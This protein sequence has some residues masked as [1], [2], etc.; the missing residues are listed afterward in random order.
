MKKLILAIVIIFATIGAKAQTNTLYFMEDV[1]RNME[2]N[3]A[4][5]PKTAWYV[6]IGLSDIFIEG[7]NSSLKL[8]DFIYKKM[9]DL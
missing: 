3:P 8:S 5:M 7:G 9:V 4:F 2:R 1:P 6:G